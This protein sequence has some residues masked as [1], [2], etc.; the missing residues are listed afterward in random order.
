MTETSDP[1]V[2]PAPPSTVTLSINELHELSR[3]QLVARSERLGIRVRSE[4]SLHQLVM[5]QVRHHAA[6]GDR[7]EADG[8]IELDNQ[9]GTL[10]WPKFHLRPCPEDVSVPSSLLEPLRLQAGQQL[11]VSVRGPRQRE[12]GLVAESL[13]AVEGIPAAEWKPTVDFE[14]LTALFPDRRILLEVPGSP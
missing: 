12:H 3:K 6:Q 11:R 9:R 14:K 10:R 7:V 1:P 5:D 2:D 8:I 13:V 4:G